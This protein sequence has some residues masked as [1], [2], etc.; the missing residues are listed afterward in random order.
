MRRT[1]AESQ[2]PIAEKGLKRSWWSSHGLKPPV[3]SL[4]DRSIVEH[5]MRCLLRVDPSELPP[6]WLKERSN[7]MHLRAALQLPDRNESKQ[8]VSA[9][10]FAASDVNSPAMHARGASA[11]RA[12]R[13]PRD[14]RGWRKGKRSGG[15][16]G[17]NGG[18][19]QPHLL[20]EPS[21]QQQQHSGP[22]RYLGRRL[23]QYIASDGNLQQIQT[24]RDSNTSGRSGNP[25]DASD[26][27]DW[28]GGGAGENAGVRPA[29]QGVRQAPPL[30]RHA[31][32]NGQQ[33]RSRL[34]VY[35]AVL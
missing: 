3:V 30:S 17:G 19:R 16:G 20:P 21:L 23:G 35:H 11:S 27:R 14:G 15:S 28:P 33:R 34:R 13:V 9:A 18:K 31:H 26:A 6:R 25:S 7:A 12:S 4:D 1:A 8:N 22:M 24:G 32:G 10:P 2:H 29:S 5:Q